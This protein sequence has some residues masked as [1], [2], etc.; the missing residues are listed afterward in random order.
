MNNEY[1]YNNNEQK[2]LKISHNERSC[3]GHK[4]LRLGEHVKQWYQHL[5]AVEMKVSARTAATPP[6]TSHSAS[7]TC[8]TCPSSS[9]SKVGSELE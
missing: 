9:P 5:L 1:K 7:A 8:E 6:Q 3:T 2:D 4:R